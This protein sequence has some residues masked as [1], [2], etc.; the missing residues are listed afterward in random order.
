MKNFMNFIKELNLPNKLTMLRMVLVPVYLVL[1][2]VGLDWPAL[3][4]FAVASITDLLDGIVG[5]PTTLF[6]DGS[7]ALVGEPIVGANVEG[8]KAAAE[9]LLSG[10]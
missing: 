4:V 5:V 8:C 6:V 7:G 3:I 2:A 1:L 10:M 9:A